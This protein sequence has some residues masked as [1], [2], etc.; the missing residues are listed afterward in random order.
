[1]SGPLRN[2]LAVQGVQKGAADPV[3]GSHIAGHCP[4]D[5]FLRVQHHVY[6]E[7]HPHHGGG[8]LNILPDGVAL[9][10]AGMGSFLH[11]AAVVGLNRRPG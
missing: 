1:M 9:Q 10:L 3:R 5:L 8:L 11:H 4:D 2:L 7:V 6:D